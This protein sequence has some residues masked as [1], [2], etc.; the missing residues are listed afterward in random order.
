V[1]GEGCNIRPYADGGL[2]LL[3]VLGLIAFAVLRRR[4]K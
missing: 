2:S 4:M 3:P 1:Q